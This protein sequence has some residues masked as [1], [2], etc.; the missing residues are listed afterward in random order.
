M[1]RN[2]YYEG[3]RSDH[4][5]GTR[6][7]LAGHATDK[8]LAELWRW[9][10]ERKHEVWP[11]WA[12]GCR[13]VPPARVEGARLRVSM[14]G[15]ASVLIQTHGVNL[16]VDPVYARRASPVRFAG[17]KRV[18]D[19]GVAMDDLPALDAILVTHNHYDHMD[20]AALSRLARTR[21]CRVVAPLGND[22]IMKRRDR[23]IAAEAHDWGARVDIAA[24]VAVH[25]EPA[26][27][28]SARGVRDRRMALWCGF[29]VETPAGAIYVTGDTGWG[30]GAIF[31]ALRA[32]HGGFR[33][34]L[35]PIGAYEPRW[36]MAAQHVA[37]HESVA[38][39]QAVGAR[40]AL[41]CHWGTFQLTD[42]AIDAPPRALAE[43]LAQAR[44]DPALFH[45]KRPGE[46]LAL[47]F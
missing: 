23:A 42:E 29:V 8:S 7:F 14:I 18:N 39:M 15:H 44:V 26:C 22:A 24:G 19:P 25:L 10:R 35:I 5:D 36:F 6:F 28:W 40:E 38:I 1:A 21:P 37:P 11:A 47:T 12:P 33:L 41:A 9:R 17:P 2:P 30:D 16:L 34:A 31:S 3:P 43:A 45:V 20:L 27:H 4:F 46:T 13:D 32:K